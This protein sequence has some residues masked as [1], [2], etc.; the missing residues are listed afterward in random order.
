VRETYCLKIYNSKGAGKNRGENK[1][2]NWEIAADCTQRQH[3]FFAEESE[4]ILGGEM[5]RKPKSSNRRKSLL[6]FSNE[7]ES[8]KLNVDSA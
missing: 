4:R 2:R 8:R 6:K 7:G 1:R 5:L 3:E